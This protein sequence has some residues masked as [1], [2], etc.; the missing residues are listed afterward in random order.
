ME[1]TVGPRRFVAWLWHPVVIATA[2]GLAIRIGFV[3]IRPDFKAAGDAAYYHLEANLLAS[4]QGWI[5][6]F[7]LIGSGHPHVA[8]ASFPPLFTLV[9]TA[10][11]LVGFKSFFAHRMWCAVIG[12][13]AV[14]LGAWV[15]RE[16]TTQPASVPGPGRAASGWRT[17]QHWA[18]ILAAFGIAVYPNLWIPDG[19]GMSEA[20]SPVLVL[21]VLGTAYRL[22][23]APSWQR[24]AVLGG[25]LALAAL[26]RDEMAL[27]VVFILVPLAL[28]RRVTWRERGRMLGAGL[29]VG[30]LVVGPWVGYNLSRFQDPVFIS[31][32]LGITLASANCDTTWHGTNTGYWSLA[33]AVAAHPN[34]H[35]DESVQGA[36]DQHFALTYVRNNL[37]GL[38]R[39]ELARLG[40]AFG[41]YRPVQQIN[42]DV[43]F[44]S[45]PKTWAFAG[46]GMYYGLALLAIPGALLLYRRRITLLPMVAV[47][48]DVVISVLLTFG[49]T[50]YRSTFE[51]VL[52]LLAAVAVAACIQRLRRPAPVPDVP[53]TTG[54]PA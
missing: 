23:R 11:S 34:P 44:E 31:D 38:P 47:L 33:C 20:L 1:L 16:I 51:P 19:L 52:V 2:L 54:G 49:Q 14:P 42:L 17:V 18:P 7:L 4:G 28:T 27:L 22:W 10:S 35:V 3:L 25:V 53:A 37:G 8:D 24:A 21:L 6:P 40:R 46:L 32:G 29:V 48:A 39:V 30:A 43:F 50:R 41:L 5:N 12:A 36:E 15:A 45:R 26:A 9:L 13:A